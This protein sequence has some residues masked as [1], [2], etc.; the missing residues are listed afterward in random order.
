MKKLIITLFALLLLSISAQAQVN[1]GGHIGFNRNAKDNST[2]INLR[3]DVSY[4]TGNWAF[5]VFLE[6][7]FYRYEGK[8]SNNMIGISPYV[9]YTLFKNNYFYVYMEGGLPYLLRTYSDSKT[10]NQS[11][12]A[13]YLGPGLGIILSDHWSLSGTFGKVE[14]NTYNKTLNLSMDATAVSLGV[15]YVF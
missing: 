6:L 9:Q 10:P 4:E 3:P 1:L 2:E 12:W 5:G 11:Q 13:P 15:Y 8:T 7:Q 14:Y